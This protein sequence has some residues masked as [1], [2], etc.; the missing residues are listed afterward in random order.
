MNIKAKNLVVWMLL[1]IF[2]YLGYHDLCFCLKFA[3]VW[4]WSQMCKKWK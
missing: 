3:T 1:V 4:L 2:M